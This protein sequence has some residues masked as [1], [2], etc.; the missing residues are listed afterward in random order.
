MYV[1]ITFTN[2]LRRFL[3]RACSRDKLPG[4]VMTST[5][6]ALYNLDPARAIARIA[7]A[8][9][10]TKNEYSVVNKYRLRHDVEKNTNELISEQDQ[11]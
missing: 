1:Y 10:I 8:V 2:R 3:E 4:R 6:F 5:P 7:V 11:T 9:F